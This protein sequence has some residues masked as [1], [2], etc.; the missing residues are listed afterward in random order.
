[1]I[2]I[3]R[4]RN[5]T[6]FPSTRLA[7]YRWLTNSLAAVMLAMI[8]AFTVLLW[9]I[10]YLGFNV[11]PLTATIVFVEPGSSAAYAGLQSG[12][13]VLRIY[14][15]SWDESGLAPQCSLPAWAA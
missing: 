8:L 13:R 5:I 1:V 2:F 9:P 15:H 11:E 14:D 6:W 4:A 12:D 7:L 3:N 10:P